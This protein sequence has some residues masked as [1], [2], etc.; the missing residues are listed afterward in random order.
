MAV[1]ENLLIVGHVK[2]TVRIGKM[3]TLLYSE[4]L[5]HCCNN[6]HRL[7]AVAWTSATLHDNSCDSAPQLNPM[8]KAMQDLGFV[9]E[10]G[11]YCN[12]TLS[13]AGSRHTNVMS[14]ALYGRR[15]VYSRLP[16]ISSHV[17]CP[18]QPH[19]KHFVFPSRFQRC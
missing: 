4:R 17:P 2:A 12:Y 10:N 3:E 7:S 9:G 1:G 16:T 5:D 11:S 14:V 13:T 6:G 18:I 15:I 19:K 8:W